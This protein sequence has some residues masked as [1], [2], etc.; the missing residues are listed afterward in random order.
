MFLRKLS[1][2]LLNVLNGSWS[3]VPF[4]QQPKETKFWLSFLYL[5][6]P[7]KALHTW[8]L[9]RLFLFNEFSMREDGR[10]PLILTFR[11]C[12]QIALTLTDVKLRRFRSLERR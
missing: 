1:A 7:F 3:K 4:D 8:F 6:V 11:E 10:K 2:S 9:E 12:W 5:T